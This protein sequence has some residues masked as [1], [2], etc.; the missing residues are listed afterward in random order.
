MDGRNEAHFDKHRAWIKANLGEE[1]SIYKT[2]EADEPWVRLIAECSNAVRHEET[3]LKLEVE[4]FALKPG[5]KIAPPAWRYD[6][7]KK[8]LERQDH[9]TDL[10][11]DLDVRIYNMLTF[12]EEILVLCLQD[13]LKDHKIFTIFRRT[14]EQINPKCPIVYE[15][16]LKP[17]FAK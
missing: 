14:K 6:L 4:N 8:G 5:N 12:F 11:H 16:S 2:L 7:T 10:I 17:Q 3:G 9:Y 15:V 1:H 13:E